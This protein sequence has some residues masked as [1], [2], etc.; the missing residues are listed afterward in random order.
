MIRQVSIP[1]RKLR[2]LVDKMA[3][4]K[5]VILRRD[6][7]GVAHERRRVDDE[8]AGHLARD[9]VRVLETD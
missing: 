1:L 8:R 6:G 3:S 7:K 5:E 9:P 2:A 4:E